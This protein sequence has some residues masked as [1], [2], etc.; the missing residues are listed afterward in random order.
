MIRVIHQLTLGA[1]ALFHASAAMT[2][3]FRPGD[4]VFIP[5]F[6]ENLREDGYA[7][8][9]VDSVTTDGQLD[10]VISRFEEG[11]GKTLYGTCS[12]NSASV[13]AGARIVSD[14]PRRLRIEHN[15]D[16]QDVLPY[17]EGLDQYLERENLSTV[18]FKWLGDGMAITP[19]R[20]EVAER[21]AMD[22]DLPRIALA[23]ELAREQVRST[24]GNG[25][26]VP[27]EQALAGAPPMLAAV[28]RKLQE[29]PDG[30]DAAA[31]IL[32]GAEPMQGDDL[33]A[34]VIARIAL[35]VREQLDAVTAQIGEPEAAG[36]DLA[37]L[38]AVY[39]G[40]YRLMTAD[41]T[42]PYLNADLDYYRGQVQ[43]ALARGEWP[44][45]Y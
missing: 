23:M 40:W 44:R 35:L 10:V 6:S 42:R 4:R 32:S 27:P 14:E 3:E 15:I 8:G 43:E 41:D 24:G 9:R 33:L 36:D 1:L 21:R 7:T 12:P 20:L 19:Q 39:L 11:K 29:A 22:L 28:G 34:S 17:R 18:I 45:L 13:M 5:L 37:G 30:L 31:L 16:P 2:Q 38:E 25:F 26:P